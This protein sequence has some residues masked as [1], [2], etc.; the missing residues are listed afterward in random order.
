MG[1]GCCGAKKTETKLV[2][3]KPER[4]PSP[5]K[6]NP[7]NPINPPSSVIIGGTSE[8]MKVTPNQNQSNIIPEPSRN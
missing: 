7:L 2:G 8:S 6:P 5:S 1:Q 4:N 3:T